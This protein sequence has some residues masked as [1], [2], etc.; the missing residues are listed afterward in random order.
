MAKT[1][2]VPTIITDQKPEPAPIYVVAEPLRH[3]GVS[4]HPGDHAPDLDKATLADLMA[5]GVIVQA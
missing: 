2:P 4:Y 3:D 5:I 1:I